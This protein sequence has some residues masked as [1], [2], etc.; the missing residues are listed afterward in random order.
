MSA[1]PLQS[2]RSELR[3][4]ASRSTNEVISFGPF[5]LYPARRL[6]ERAGVS[7]RLGGRA[8]DIL[9][10]LVEHAGSVVGKTELTARVWP[11][12]TID[13][14]CLRVQVA[15]LRK[16]LGDGEAGNRYVTTSTGQGYC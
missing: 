8:F 3:M 14:G 16:A 9:S 6:L 13:E 5:R 12:V 15:A 11:G 7:L 2:V 10:V 4:Y 1:S